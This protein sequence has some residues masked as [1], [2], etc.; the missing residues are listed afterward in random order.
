VRRAKHELVGAVIVEVD[1]A[2]V[3][4]ENIGDLPRD[5]PEHLLEVE[6]RVHRCDRLREETQMAL[7]YVHR[8]S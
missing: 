4:I 6:R 5:E 8:I 1:E 7:S 2:G 3:G